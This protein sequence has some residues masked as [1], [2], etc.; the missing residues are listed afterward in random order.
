MLVVVV[1]QKYREFIPKLL[2]AFQ[3]ANRWGQSL[4]LRR[5]WITNNAHLLPPSFILDMATAKKQKSIDR[6]K[7]FR[8]CGHKIGSFTEEASCVYDIENFL[9]KDIYPELICQIDRYFMFGKCHKNIIQKEL[10]SLKNCIL[11]GHPRLDILSKK[12]IDIYK[13][14]I[15]KIKQLYNRKFLIMINSNIGEYAFSNKTYQEFVNINID[16]YGSEKKIQDEIKHQKKVLDEQIMVAKKIIES[17]YS[18]DIDV[19][20]RPHPTCTKKSLL[21]FINNYSLDI[22]VDDRFSIVPWLHCVNAIIHDKCTTAIEGLVAGVIPF[23]ISYNKSSVDEINPST[24][25]SILS[26]NPD[27]CAKSIIEHLF[28]NKY[29]EEINRKKKILNNYYENLENGSI[30]TILNSIEEFSDYLVR[31][32]EFKYNFYSPPKKIQ[33]IKYF[34][35]IKNNIYKKTISEN[36]KKLNSQLSLNLTETCH[37]L[38]LLNKFYNTKIKVNE[39][40]KEVFLLEK[41]S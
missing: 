10:K 7:Y 5:D 28:H 22:K 26:D 8:E 12:F 18:N 20:M 13:K 41:S 19:V 33:I 30:K 24:E 40:A 27:K 34:K 32:N 16:F 17:P 23:S 29:Y 1:H 4:I 11:S 3:A 35:K 21:Q 2:L 37:V 31:N 25:V 36:P 39:L 14:E 38:K 15:K 6:I 9:K